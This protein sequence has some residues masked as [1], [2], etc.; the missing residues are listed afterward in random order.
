MKKIFI[1]ICVVALA[2]GAILAKSNNEV[3]MTVSGRPVFKSEFEYLYNKNMGQQ[4]EYQNLDDYVEMFVNYKL[5]V[6]DALANRLDTTPEFIEELAT[7]RS[8]LSAPYLIDKKAEKEIVDQAYDHYKKLRKIAHIMFPDPARQNVTMAFID[9]IRGEIVE[10]RLDWDK[11][12]AEYSIDRPT[13]NI[14]GEMGW[15]PVGRYPVA[16][17]DM[18]YDTEVGKISEP[19]NSGYGI[20][21]IKVEAEKD[22][23]GEVKA[24]HILKLTAQ[25]SEK[26]VIRAKEQ[27]DSIY[28]VLMGGADFADVARRESEDPGSK[29][30]GGDLDWFGPAV[31]VE[32]FDSAAFSMAEG[33]ISHPVRTPYGWHIIEVTGHRPMKSRSEMEEKLIE[34]V[35]NSE[36]GLIPRQRFIDSMKKKYGAKILSDNLD[37]VEEM[38]NANVGGLTNEYKKELLTSTLPIAEV[39][40]QPI[41]LGEAL[42]R[43]KFYGELNGKNV[44]SSLEETAEHLLADKTV[45]LVEK[46]LM[47]TNENYRNLINEYS[48]GILLFNISQ[49]RVWQKAT[50]ERDGLENYFRTHRDRYKF[51]EPRF[52][53]VIVFTTSDSLETAIKDYIATLDPAET[54]TRNIGE[55]LKKKFGRDVRSDRVIAKKGE[56]AITDFIAFGG[57]RPERSNNSWKCFF[58][59]QGEIIDQPMEADDVKGKV[60]GDYQNYLEQ[61]WIKELRAKYPV[62]IDKKVLK[63]VKEIPAK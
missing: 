27:I 24:R 16:F 41:S 1:S 11:A 22:N 39:S 58:A 25:K 26:D 9:S 54:T 53:G 60:S 42:K 62:K 3:L 46:E 51:D 40:G 32:P 57:E 31:M 63:K 49:D 35:N 56:N 28:N 36:R 18:V 61:E 48:D 6:A 2:V 15:L 8:E 14:G 45:E 44:R 55:I 50:T 52:K 59:Y 20:H 21:L 34:Q 38:V 23:P 7:Y 12:A 13:A 33:V 10:G 43:T 19:V 30:S 17:E 37:K 5:K 4:L 47:V 29:N